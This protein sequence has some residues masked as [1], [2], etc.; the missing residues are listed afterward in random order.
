MESFT[1]LTEIF[2]GPVV[3]PDGASYDDVRKIHNGDIDKRPA[4]IARCR[5]MAD[6]AD[7]IRFARTKGLEI[8]VRGGG[9]NVGGRAIANGG[10]MVDLSL[11]KGVHIDPKGRTAVVEG[12]VL[13]KEFNR[14]AQ[15]YGLA[16]TGGVIGTTG[17]AGLT[18]GGGLGWLMPKYGMALDNLIAVNLVLADGS[19]ARASA[20]ENP[21][22]FWAVRGGGGNFGV[23]ASFEFR[24]HPVGPM[25]IG[26]LVAF[27][28][29]E[30]GKVFRAFREFAATI[31]DD[32]MLVAAL[33]HAPDGSGTKIAAIVACYLGTEVDGMAIAA[34]IKTFG[35]V[36]VDA[37][38][39]IPYTVINGMLDG[40]FPPGA[41][42]YWKSDFHPKLEDGAIDALIV[43]FEKC[44][45]A[46]SSLLLEH[47]HGAVTRVP[48]DATAFALRD[49]GF[50]ML[51]AGQWMDRAD[52][53]A[54]V[55]WVRDTHSTLAPFAGERRYANYIG[56]DEEEVAAAKAAYGANL[57][58]LRKIKRQYDPDNLFHHNLNIPPA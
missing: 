2:M 33:T 25:V 29:P 22:L 49:P 54:A 58:R 57:D 12:G 38:G 30:A 32:L 31:P 7:A 36:A 48:I 35:T 45:V 20:D 10:M 5:G 14:E 39:P 46:T 21:D 41:F 50:N 13:W 3:L 26:G 8:T 24:L 19:I 52:R 40:G 43:A 53:A 11:M 23:A 42:N 37:M 27:P 1:E 17:V 6:I 55:T 15:L 44:P 47:F 16:T 34:K 51:I 4:V 28:F 56:S 9:H 18:L